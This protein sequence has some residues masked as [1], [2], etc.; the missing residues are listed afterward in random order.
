M[1]VAVAVGEAVAV[2]AAGRIETVDTTPNTAIAGGVGSVPR[3]TVVA[4]V[5]SIVDVTLEL[6]LSPRL[7]LSLRP[8]RSLEVA[9]SLVLTTVDGPLV[10]ERGDAASARAM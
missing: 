3:L 9:P 7:A 4:A 2:A 1:A 6:A 10:V 5:R 8:A